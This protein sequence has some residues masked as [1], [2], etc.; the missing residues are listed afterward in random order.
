MKK[1]NQANTSTLLK[2][3]EI[4]GHHAKIENPPYM[5][6]SVEKLRHVQLGSIDWIIVALGHYGEMN[7]DL[8]ADPTMEFLVDVAGQRAFPMYWKNDY[9]GRDTEAMWIDES[10]C[11]NYR[12]KAQADITD[13]ANIW[14]KNI[15]EQGF[16]QAANKL[17]IES[18]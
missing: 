12:E 18:K 2:L 7:G 4:A 3:L 14:L 16:I 1:L 17:E 8:M 9:A 5:P 6:L 10:G 11:I 15:R 13:F